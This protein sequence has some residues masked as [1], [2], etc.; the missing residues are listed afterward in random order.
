MLTLKSIEQHRISVWKCKQ[1]FSSVTVDE[2]ISLVVSCCE[3]ESMS[4]TSEGECSWRCEF[5]VLGILDPVGDALWFIPLTFLLF[6]S[7]FLNCRFLK[8]P[9]YFLST[10]S[11]FADPLSITPDDFRRL[12]LSPLQTALFV[13]VSCINSLAVDSLIILALIQL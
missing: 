6:L 5:E 13:F 3:D 7:I 12:L 1:N 9:T 2:S 11:I 4:S 8:C 10:I